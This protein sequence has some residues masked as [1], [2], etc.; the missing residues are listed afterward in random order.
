MADLTVLGLWDGHD[1]GVALIRDGSLQFAVSE[2]RLS[3]VKRA[4]GFPSLALQACLSQC[5]V[6]PSEIDVIAVPGRFGRLLHRAGDAV[7]RRSSTQRDPMGLS[8]ILAREME[9]GMARLP[10]LR[11]LESKGSQAV[12]ARR[13][14]RVGLR[15]PVVPVDHH[16]AHAW[17]ARLGGLPDT[18]VVTMDGYGDGLAAT[19]DGPGPDREA[20]SSPGCSVALVY[21]AVTRQLGFSEGEEG[22]VMGLAAHGDPRPLAPWFR[23]RMGFESCLPSLGG[24]I[25]RRALTEHRREDVA[26]A[27]Q[28]RTEEVVSGWIDARRQQQTNIALSGGLFAN[29]SLNGRL[30]KQFDRI[31]VFPHMGD[32]G[33]CVGAALAVTGPVPFKMPFLGPDYAGDVI[34]AALHKRGLGA[35]RVDHP[36]D[37]LLGVID[38][39]GIVGRFVGRS[40]FGPRALGHRSILCRADR[41][42]ILSDLGDR[43]DREPF[44]PF[45]PIRRTGAGSATMTVVVDADETLRRECPAAVHVDNTVRTQ[46]ATEENDAGMWR[47]LGRAESRGM[48]ALINTSFNRHQEPIVETPDDAIETF[49]STRLDAMQLGGFVVRRPQ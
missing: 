2:E 6:D 5:N 15:A 44:M 30:A 18:M 40:E 42:A 46:V 21:G 34:E 22:K 47:L 32:G 33:L 9:L 17:T 4:Q 45:A 12:L 28:H 8:S 13:L 14:R 49:L 16:D 36:E 24:R 7:Y 25:G 23:E 29:A 39:G 43:L 3:R 27:L 1:A 48:P 11:R 10:T 20:L 35:A 19:F 26:A 38:E 37:V 41:P 31:F